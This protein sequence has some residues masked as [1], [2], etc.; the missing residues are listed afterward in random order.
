MYTFFKNIMPRWCHIRPAYFLQVL[1]IAGFMILSGCNADSGGY[2]N[3]RT[4]VMSE[5]SRLTAV[6]PQKRAILLMR[7][8]GRT[9]FCC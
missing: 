1:L 4:T 5:E 6:I 7:L 2:A 3:N 9:I 8:N